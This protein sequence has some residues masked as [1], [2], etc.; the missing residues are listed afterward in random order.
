MD[1][2][3]INPDIVHLLADDVVFREEEFG[4]ILFYR[5]Q[6]WTFEINHSGLGVVMAIRNNEGKAIKEVLNGSLEES[7]D[8]LQFL[9]V[10]GLMRGVSENG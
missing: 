7:A 4:G 2:I 6:L 3:Q 9:L 8:F 10:N 1:H 5:P